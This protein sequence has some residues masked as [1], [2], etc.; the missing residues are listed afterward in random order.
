MCIPLS[1]GTYSRILPGMV[2]QGWEA[3]LS[4]SGSRKTDCLGRGALRKW[5]PVLLTPRPEN[6]DRCLLFRSS[7]E[8]SPLK[9]SELFHNVFQGEHL[10][11]EEFSLTSLGV[12]ELKEVGDTGLEPVTSTV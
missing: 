11:C 1:L 2:Q 12:K 7:R 8:E 3:S 10:P 5:L 9:Q 6:R 4:V